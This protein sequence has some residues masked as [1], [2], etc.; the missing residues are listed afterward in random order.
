MHRGAK[1]E[2]TADGTADRKCPQTADGSVRCY[3]CPFSLP[4]GGGRKGSGD[5]AMSSFFPGCSYLAGVRSKVSKARFSTVPHIPPAHICAS[6]PEGWSG[7]WRGGAQCPPHGDSHYVRYGCLCK[8]GCVGRW[9]QASAAGLG[10]HCLPFT[11]VLCLLC[12]YL[13]GCI[14]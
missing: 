14:L 12:W 11:L 5:N 10:L 3:F 9:L 6:G 1:G 4:F 8:G 7:S 13:L 2:E